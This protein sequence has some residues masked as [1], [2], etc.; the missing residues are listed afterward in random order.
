MARC[1]VVAIDGP[2]GAGKSTIARAVARRLGYVYI[3]TGAMYR[4][5]ALWA[6]RNGIAPDDSH[7]L[8]E[9]ARHAKIEFTAGASTV[10]LNG[11]DVTAAIREPEVSGAASK[12]SALPGVRRAMVDAQREMA[13]GSSVVMEGRDIGTVVFPDAA[14]KIFLDANPDVRAT[15]RVEELRGKGME[16]G[17]E[18]VAQEMADRDR[19]DRTRTEAPL[20][21]APDAIYVDTTGLTIEEV[22]EA[23]LKVIRGRVSNGK[24]VVR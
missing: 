18:T 8:D 2:A 11:E 21:Q 5:V 4:A 13:T 6:L 23:V 1:V 24:D 17:A 20:V 10:V 19:R 16:V 9:L 12:A 15:R 14:V 7:K 22:E 3:D